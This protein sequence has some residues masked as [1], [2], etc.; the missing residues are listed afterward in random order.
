[1]L[2]ER[3][4]S[5]HDIETKFAE[6]I[7]EGVTRLGERCFFGCGALSSVTLPDNGIVIPENAFHDYPRVSF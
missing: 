5:R 7:P 3:W 6:S 4:F 2:L 1:M